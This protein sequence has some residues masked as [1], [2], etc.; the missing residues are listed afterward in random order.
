[1]IHNPASIDISQTFQ[2]KLMAFDF[3]R[4]P[5]RQG[6]LDDPTFGTIHPG[7]KLVD[8]FSKLI[9]NMSSDDACIHAKPP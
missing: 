7:G 1:V 6:L 3:K 5:R 9:W 8:L 2:C 4:D